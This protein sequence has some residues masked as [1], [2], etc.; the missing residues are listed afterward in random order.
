MSVREVSQLIQP[1]PASDGDG[2]RREGGAVEVGDG[3]AAGDEEL[4]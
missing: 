3:D 2:V 1:N 4:G